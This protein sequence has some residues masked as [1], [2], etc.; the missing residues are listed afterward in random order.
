MR[1]RSRFALALAALFALVALALGLWAA[2]LWVQLEAPERAAIG[3]TLAR[4]G[5]W[6]VVLPLL[7]LGA[8]GLAL[9][10]PWLGYVRAARRV[11]EQTRLILGANPAHRLGVE[12]AAEVREVASAVNALA[13]RYALA[14]A[15]VEAEVRRARAALEAEH[16]R[17]AALVAE[18]AEGVVVC[19]ADGTVLLLNRRARQLLGAEGAAGLGRSLFEALPEPPIRHALEGQRHAWQHGT[20]PR[21]ARFVTGTGDGRLLRATL[22]PVLEGS[23]AGGITSFVLTLEDVTR[24]V[25]AEHARAAVLRTLTER[26]RASLAGIRAAIETLDAHEAMDA[27]QAARFRAVIRDEALELGTELERTLAE[28][29]EA[30]AARGPLDEVLAP[31]LLGAL[32]RRIEALAGVPALVEPGTESETEQ[33]DGGV[34]LWLRVDSYALVEALAGNAARIAAER[35]VP[36]FGLRLGR[37]GALAYLDVVWSGAL[38]A[39]DKLRGWDAEAQPDAALRAAVERHGGEVWGDRDR[40]R[41]EAFLRVLLPLAAP[42]DPLAHIRVAASTGSRPEFYDFDLFGRAAQQPPEV[43]E[44]RLADLLYTVIDLET[45]G[46]DPAG[47]DRIV[48]VGAVRIANRRLLADETF[49]QL[50]DP[51][52]AVPP[53]STAIHGLT[54][55][56]LAGAPTIEQVLPRLSR[57]VG[58]TVLVG[59]NVAFDLRFL[60]L[61]AAG[62]GVRFTQP[63]LDTLLLSAAVHPEQASHA[64][65]AVAARLGLAVGQRHTALGDARLTGAVL[66]KL[67]PLL[68]ER[69]IM[70]LGEAIAASRETM[71]ARLRY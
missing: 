28:S 69:G 23:V 56:M 1:G 33:A 52:R 6:L 38:G 40:A 18:L 24:D 49:E 4:R 22:A 7:L 50:V 39:A 29:A 10:A 60:E 67:L 55:E 12:G 71:F 66:L 61:A 57:F 37:S 53:E 32:A 17:L 59:H 63:V 35:R 19:D 31:D 13:D 15:D 3:A 2:G 30:L 36:A 65:E 25:A 43:A 46:L 21:V 41:G 26:V 5:G 48:A 68:E 9:R 45:T 14:L 54:R 20:P 62:T 27:A 64:L 51:L 8:L 58:D 42:P 11:A 16:G 44:R 34:P 47:G 70:T